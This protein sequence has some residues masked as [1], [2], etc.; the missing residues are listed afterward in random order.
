MTL[1]RPTA[2]INSKNAMLRMSRAE[3]GRP[4]EGMKQYRIFLGFASENIIFQ[5]LRNAAHFRVG[6]IPRLSAGATWYGYA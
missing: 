6:H 3:T 1:N 4:I 5:M 2:F